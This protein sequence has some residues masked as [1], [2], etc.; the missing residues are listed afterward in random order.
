[1]EV[2]TPSGTSWG[3]VQSDGW[4]PQ[5]AHV[6][7]RALG[8]ATGR[9]VYGAGYQYSMGLLPFLYTNINC[10]ARPNVTARRRGKR[11]R[12]LRLAACAVWVAC[13]FGS[14]A[15]AWRVCTAGH[16]CYGTGGRG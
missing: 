7:C 2:V 6:A 3:L 4:G 11:G 8:W 15:H 16:Q 9:P 13:I 5:D 1:M 12:M 10:K 14:W